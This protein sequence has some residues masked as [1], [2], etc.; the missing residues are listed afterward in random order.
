MRLR[1][2]LLCLALI[3]GLMGGRFSFAQWRD[4][5]TR[6]TA[7]NDS[8]EIGINKS[9]GMIEH[10]FDRISKEDYCQ[11]VVHGLGP[12][13]GSAIGPQAVTWLPVGTDP[14]EVPAGD[15]VVGPRPVGLTLFD[16]LKEKEFSDL[17]Q[18]ATIHRARIEFGTLSFE[19][20]FPGADFV[21]LETFRLAPDHLRWEVRVKKTAGAGRTVRVIQFVPLPLGR[22]YGWAPISD[23]PFAVR[24]YV[25]FAIEYG[26]SV[27]GPVGESRWRTMIPMMVFYSNQ[28]HRALSLTSPFEVP[29]VRIRFLNNTGATSDF[30]WN[31]RHYPLRERPYLQVSHEYLGLRD[32]KDIEVGLLIAAHPADWRPALGWVYSMYRNY[33]DPDPKF[34]QW[35]GVYTEKG[36]EL[37]RDSYTDADRRKI[38]DGRRERGVRWEEFHGHF[39]WYGSMIPSPDVTSWTCESHPLP[40]ATITRERIAAHARLDKEFSIGTFLYY[41]I[42]EA[43]HW[44]AEK[45][46]P[47]SIARDEEG[48]PIGA[49]NAEQYPD[50]HAC[51]L[52]NADPVSPFGKHMIRQAGEM[53]EAYP[54]LAGFLWDV[55][56]RS[57]MFDFAHD[58]GI[59]MVNNRP[60][61]YPAFMYERMMR[62]HIG[63]LLRS[64][65]MCF[66]A[67]KPVTITACEGLD[68]IM[69]TESTPDEEVPAWIT[70]QS[71]LGL[72][73]HVMILDTTSGAHAELMLLNCL[74]YGMFYSDLETTDEQERPLPAERIAAN[75]ELARTYLPY[76]ERFRGKK[77]VFYPQA[78]ELPPH[79]D[80][81]IFRLKDGSGMI[82]MV[83]LWRSIRT[84]GGFDRNLN[85]ICRLPDAADLRHVYAA[86]L[87]LKETFR[88]EPERNGDTLKI[89]VPRHGK[90]TVIPLSSRPDPKLE[91][92]R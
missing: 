26:Q 20:N 54:E 91:G 62:D 36:R 88:L 18:N 9:S 29:A 34:D 52:M 64:K 58:D 15:F 25:P 3:L 55:Y 46:F 92:V 44:Y 66:T 56:G 70:A 53:A 69:S 57:C 38:L 40:G 23:A 81:N 65:G 45:E 76:V 51:W 6:W 16:E 63:P 60:A 22:Y 28:T 67:N 73:R 5:G 2:C 47:E 8:L 42:T 49:F 61:Y 41:N 14:D 11:Q 89:T 39:L 71:Y 10:L 75:A 31:S 24:P 72:N 74:R 21:V 13:R 80:G 79:T 82:T 59:T 68:G 83:S 1:A 48:K 30:H 50:R 84:V 35:D 4:E 90:A 33:F 19:K 77:W 27:S 7:T 43:E 37:M 32:K 85:V 86:A 12:A 78:L 17:A 87:D